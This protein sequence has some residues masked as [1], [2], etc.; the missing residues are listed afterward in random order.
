MRLNAWL[1]VLAV[2][3]ISA[4]VAYVCLR[5]PPGP[6]A[7]DRIV[8]IADW[9]WYPVS[10]CNETDDRELV[11]QIQLQQM[12]AIRRLDVREVWVEGLSDETIADFRRHVRRL[13]EVRVPDGDGPV[14][15][16]VRDLYAEDLL[17]IGAAGRLLLNKE[18]DEVL[19]LENHDAWQ[20]AQAVDCVIPEASDEA[21]ER[22]MAKRLPSRA[23]IVLGVYHDLR[24]HLPA[25]VDYQVVRVDAMPEPLP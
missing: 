16:L 10:E 8:H 11:E 23:V 9:H 15:Q 21:R 4:T 7:P 3:P 5:P 20:A 2:L 19:P 12:D 13:R 1:F 24:K 6:T 22:A 17:L 18:I 14:D 25:E